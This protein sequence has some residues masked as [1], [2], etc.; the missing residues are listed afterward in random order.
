MVPWSYAWPIGLVF[1]IWTCVVLGRPEVV[2][3]FHLSRP[4][5]PLVASPAPRAGIAGQFRSLL[6]SM[7]RYMLPTVLRAESTAS[8]PDHERSSIDG[9]VKKLENPHGS[10]N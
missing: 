7:G 2:Q 4:E 5:I 9:P 1:G 6:H 10:S 3:A 8:Q